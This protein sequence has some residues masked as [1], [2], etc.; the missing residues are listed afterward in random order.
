ML[1][2]ANDALGWRHQRV[3]ERW[4]ARLQELPFSRLAGFRPLRLLLPELRPTDQA[5]NQA[6]G[7]NVRD[8]S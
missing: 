6:G 5:S 3:H 8:H 2:D 4:H 7:E 1:I